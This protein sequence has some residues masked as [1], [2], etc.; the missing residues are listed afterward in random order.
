MREDELV[1]E[2]L[3]A[4]MDGTDDK[5]VSGQYGPAPPGEDQLLIGHEPSAGSA[6]PPGSC[7]R[8]C[9]GVG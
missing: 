4:G 8:G 2:M 9:K 5:L 1:V 6:R 3:S 7:T